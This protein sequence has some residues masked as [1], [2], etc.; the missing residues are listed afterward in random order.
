M[1]TTRKPR[2]SKKAKRAKKRTARKPKAKKLR[3]RA[4]PRTGAPRPETT[5]GKVIEGLEKPSKVPEDE[6]WGDW[7][8]H[9]E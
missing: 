9:G 1:A 7:D 3:K 5:V 6:R 4:Q 8:T 2:K